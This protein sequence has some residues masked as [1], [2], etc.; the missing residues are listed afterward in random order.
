MSNAHLPPLFD[1]EDPNQWPG[2][3]WPRLLEILRAFCL[4]DAEQDAY[5]PNLREPRYH[6]AMGGDGYTLSA[7][8]PPLAD[9]Y[10]LCA[11]FGARSEPSQD[12][13]TGRLS[14]LFYEAVERL[15]E[16]VDHPVFPYI[17][18]VNFAELQVM[19]PQLRA[20]CTEALDFFGAEKRAP[21]MTWEEIAPQ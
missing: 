8:Y 10:D 2:N 18:H 13:M 5:F 19:R 14:S 20:L 4:S 9:A 7:Y 6:S 21:Q 17:S 11:I 16:P 15:S 12:E 3:E 1:D